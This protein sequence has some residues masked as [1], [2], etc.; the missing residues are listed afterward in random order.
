[1]ALYNKIFLSYGVCI[2]LVFVLTGCATVRKPAT[3]A[4]VPAAISPSET[5]KPVEKK[6]V[7]HKVQKGETLW[8]IA[9]T[10]QVPVED[11]IQANG[12]PNAASIEENQLV[13][14]PGAT[15][16]RDVVVV[17]PTDKDADYVW[18][19]KGK[20]IAYF[21]DRKGASVNAGIDIKAVEG[22]IVKAARDGRVVFADHL[23]G[24]GQA[25]ILDHSDGF[26]TVYAHNERL[27]SQ[28]GDHVVRGQKIAQ[29]ARE[30]NLA[31][32]HFEVRKGDRPSNP[33]H[34]LP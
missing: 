1:M 22:E 31:Y 29:V 33:L 28:L 30:G 20:I 9:K 14:I 17:S 26:F 19:I 34:Y 5:Q 21:Q 3:P 4:S 13:L 27:M 6:G 12:I 18:P 25:L 8:R 23:T 7:Q 15:S 24:Y 16:V 10:Y 32:L 11:I 2:G